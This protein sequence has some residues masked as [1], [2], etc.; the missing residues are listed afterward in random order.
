MATSSVKIEL[1]L[2]NNERKP[3][4][5]RCETLSRIIIFFAKEPNKRNRITTQ[6]SPSK[7]F[8]Q[9]ETNGHKALFYTPLKIYC[10]K[11]IFTFI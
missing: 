6:F 1:T 3:G 2:N 4:E 9:Q 8:V 11:Q 5:E 10:E 7:Q